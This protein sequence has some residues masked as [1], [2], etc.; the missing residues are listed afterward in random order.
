[1]ID[2]IVGARRGIEGNGHLADD[3]NLI[4]D[5]GQLRTRASAWDAVQAARNIKR[6][7]TLDVIT[8]VF[9]RF[10]ELHGDRGFRD[11]PAIVGG[12]AELQ[13]RPV[14]IVGEQKGASTEENIQRNFGMPH[15][16]GYRKA[17]R[18]YRLAEKFHLPVITLVDTPGAYPGPEGEER[19]QAEAIAKAIFTMTR[20]ATPIIVVILGEGGSGGA[21]AL[22]IGDVVLA[23][24]NAIYSVISPEGSAAILWRSPSEAERAANAMRLA[25]PDLLDLGVVDALIPE[26]AGGAH[27]D[28]EETAKAIKIALVAQL[29]KLER[30]AT[31]D[32]LSARYERF[33]GFGTLAEPGAAAAPPAAE[34]WWRKFPLMRRRP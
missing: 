7:H 3:A 24:E 34:P 22:A 33:R 4:I 14:V 8:R 19:G 27:T 31:S 28:H 26:P 12:I 9:D 10:Q 18:L 5:S 1:M 25:G 20:L 17:I 13:G 21:L 30:A 6:P 32:L 23:L 29:A 11:D 15:P 16:E 2:R